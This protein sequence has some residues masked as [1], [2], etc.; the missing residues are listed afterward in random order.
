[1]SI[2][3]KNVEILI[4]LKVKLLKRRLSTHSHTHTFTQKHLRPI[5]YRDI[6]FVGKTRVPSKISRNLPVL[7]QSVRVK[8][9]KTSCRSTINETFF[10]K[11]S[12]LWSLGVV[13]VV[14]N[15]REQMA[16]ESEVTPICQLSLISDQNREQE[17]SKWILRFLE[18]DPWHWHRISS[19]RRLRG[20]TE[21]FF[22]PLASKGFK[23]T[24]TVHQSI[25]LISSGNG[26]YKFF[27]VHIC[28]VIIIII[29]NNNYDWINS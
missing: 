9:T 15:R 5:Y 17:L 14:I 28:F 25:S 27:L 3:A 1:M 10:W 6:R 19:P 18:T 29:N 11:L 21:A 26:L 13:F 12:N 2:L 4:L 22:R 7:C 8:S 24:K 23:T 20:G 16:G